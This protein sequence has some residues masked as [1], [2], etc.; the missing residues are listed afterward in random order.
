MCTPYSRTVSKTPVPARL[1][2]ACRARAPEVYKRLSITSKYLTH[3]PDSSPFA[4]MRIRGNRLPLQ[5]LSMRRSHT[6]TL[7]VPGTETRVRAM[8][9]E[10]ITS[11]LPAGPAHTSL[12]A[13]KVG[14]V[15]VTRR[16]SWAASRLD[17]SQS[18]R[19]TLVHEPCTTFAAAVCLVVQ[20]Q[21]SELASVR[22]GGAPGSDK[23]ALRHGST[24]SRLSKGEE[25]IRTDV[26]SA[27]I[28]EGCKT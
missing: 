11:H 7:Q 20:S 12:Q 6:N 19:Q 16:A 15:V 22:S 17:A 28:R 21:P 18:L 8:G 23:R 2:N 4:R 24:G 27:T 5:H 25:K 10:P 14:E 3:L 13:A 9:S 1:A 26:K